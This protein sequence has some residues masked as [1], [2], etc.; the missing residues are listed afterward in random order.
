M[1]KALEWAISRILDVVGKGFYGDVTLKF[2]DGHLVR[3]EH[4]QSEKPPAEARV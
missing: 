2:E 4:K 1:T 3:I